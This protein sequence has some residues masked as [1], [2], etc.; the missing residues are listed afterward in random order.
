MCNCLVLRPKSDWPNKPHL[1]LFQVGGLHWPVA[2][3]LVL[4]SSLSWALMAG[5]EVLL[6]PQLMLVGPISLGPNYWHL[7][8]TVLNLL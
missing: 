4:L 5:Q 8:G 6:E 1:T 3:H 2:S 7:W